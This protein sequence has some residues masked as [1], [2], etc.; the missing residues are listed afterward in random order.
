MKDGAIL[1]N[2]GHFDVEVSIPDLKRVSVSRKLIRNNTEEFTLPDGRRLYLLG[3]GRLVNLAAGDGHPAE[4]MDLSFSLQALS[5]IYLVRNRQALEPR[6]YNVPTEIDQKVARLRLQTWVSIDEL[7]PNRRN[8]WQAGKSEP[9]RSLRGPVI[10][11]S[12][13]LFMFTA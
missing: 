8:T 10:G 1:C 6:V 2:A 11:P 3:E 5:L 9:D 4:V 7:T 12:R 13:L